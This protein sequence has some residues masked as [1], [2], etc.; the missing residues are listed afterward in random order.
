MVCDDTFIFSFR[1]KIDEMKVR[2]S[3]DL[4]RKYIPALDGINFSNIGMAYLF[5]VLV[6]ILEEKRD[7]CLETMR[8]RNV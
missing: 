2:R 6:D 1:G 4:T 8:W 7:S 3:L 5:V